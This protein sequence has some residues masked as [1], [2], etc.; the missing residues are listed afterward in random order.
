MSLIT[1]W[2]LEDVTSVTAVLDA[3]QQWQHGLRSQPL[4]GTGSG[5]GFAVRFGLKRSDGIEDP[6]RGFSGLGRQHERLATATCSLTGE[7]FIGEN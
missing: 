7:V 3:L 6:Y 1:S 2:T 5:E 4:A